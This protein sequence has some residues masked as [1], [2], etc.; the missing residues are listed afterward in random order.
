VQDCAGGDLPEH[1]VVRATTLSSDAGKASASQAAHPMAGNSCTPTGW[2]VHAVHSKCQADSPDAHGHWRAD[3]HRGIQ[4]KPTKYAAQ[5]TQQMVIKIA[6][7]NLPTRSVSSHVQPCVFTAI[8]VIVAGIVAFQ[9][10]GQHVSLLVRKQMIQALKDNYDSDATLEHLQVRLF[11][12]VHADGDG[13]VLRYRGRK[14]LPPLMS[15][16]QFTAD[17]SWIGL[18]RSPAHVDRVRLSGLHIA[19]PPRQSD[20]AVSKPV[21]PKRNIRRF[22]IAEIDADGTLL[23]I[24]PGKPAKDPLTFAIHHLTLRGAGPDD[25][26]SFRASLTNALPTGEIVSDGQFGPWNKSQ[27]SLTALSGNYTFQQAD[28]SQF[29]GISGMLS[30]QGRYQGVLDAIQ[31]HGTTDTPDFKLDVSGNPVHLKTEFQAAVDGTDGDTR[32]EPVNAQWGSISLTAYG[33]IERKAGSGGKTIALDVT[34]PEGRLE[35]ILRLGVK[36]S[37]PIM[38]GAIAFHTKLV[39]TPGDQDIVEKLRLEGHFRTL[40][41]HFTKP[42][43]QHKVNE[44]SNRGRGDPEEADQGRVSSNFR[45]TFALTEGVMTFKN[46]AFAVPGAEIGL[47]GTYGLRSEQ[48]DFHGTAILQA[49]LSQTTTGFKSFLLKAVDP[50]FKGKHAGAIL[51]I[52]ISGSRDSPSFGL[53]LGGAK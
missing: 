30:S 4:L 12:S 17:T 31:I 9:V 2:R 51:P 26:M 3:F 46:L 47:N 36:S 10:I 27:P 19:V 42:E 21:S 29:R 34:V 5:Q 7:R 39:L 6:Q 41:A 28:L 48:L 23:E 13:L 24:L 37:R 1:V 32:L 8:T 44:L 18:L 43:I 38:T 45:G 25:P 52:K 22:V 53:D 33:T 14:D 50:F 49:K 16:K 20:S 15:V 40:A 11:P 35:D